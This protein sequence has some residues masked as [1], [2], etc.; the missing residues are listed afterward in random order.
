M[1]WRE[2]YWL[3]GT[4]SLVP[5]KENKNSC[6]QNNI[7]LELDLVSHEEVSHS[8]EDT[9][10]TPI[11][12]SAVPEADYLDIMY[13]SN[14]I[15]AAMTAQPW[16]KLGLPTSVLVAATDCR[17]I[18]I[19]RASA[20]LEYHLDRVLK[21]RDTNA[22][23][24][25]EVK[26]QCR[27]L[28]QEVSKQYNGAKFHSLSHAMHVV[29]SMN[30]LLSHVVNED[31]LNSFSLVFAC[32]LHDAGHT[33]KCS[34]FFSSGYFCLAA[35]YSHHISTFFHYVYRH[36]QHYSPGNKAPSN[37]SVQTRANPNR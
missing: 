29:T 13:S 36:E 34:P 20:L 3:I 14:E 24:S 17:E 37:G 30:K 35:C 26:I 15:H 6:I 21:H 7:P 11:I 12:E 1:G 16:D 5:S 23:M 33:G 25:E 32:L 10:S 27:K 31:P 2:T 19:I 9:P 28:V 18:H 8:T 22:K 4:T